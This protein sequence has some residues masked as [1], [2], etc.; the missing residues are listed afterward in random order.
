[1][2]KFLTNPKE[3]VQEVSETEVREVIKAKTMLAKEEDLEEI[4]EIKKEEIPKGKAIV[5][6]V[7]NRKARSLVM[8]ENLEE[9]KDL[10]N[11]LIKNHSFSL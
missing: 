4:L 1:M 8:G 5:L 7:T 10:V 11:F 9:A 2:L 3:R 6:L